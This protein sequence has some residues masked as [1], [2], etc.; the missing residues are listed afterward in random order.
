MNNKKRTGR[1]ALILLLSLL[2][3]MTF[4]PTYAFA[5]GEQGVTVEATESSIILHMGGVGSSG[6]AQIYSYTADSYF[7]A[8]PYKGISTNLDNGVFVS[9][10]EMGTTADIE[11]PR[12]TED[13][14]D[15]LYDKYYVLQGDK[16]IAGPFY[17]SEIASVGGRNVTPFEAATKKGL[18]H[19]DSST[20]NTAIDMG[21]GN[22][23]IN[24]DLGNT[25]Y[26]NEDANGNPID[27]SG[28]DAIAFTSGGE[29]FYFD[30]N[31]VESKDRTIGDYTKNGI[32]VSLVVITW[33][34]RAGE[35]YPASFRYNTNNTDTQ[36]LGFNTSN[37][38]GRKYWVAAMEFLAD[39]YSDKETGFVDQF[40]VGN[41]IDYTYDW[42]LIQPGVVNGLY[43]RADFNT[44]MEEYARTFRLA[45]LAVKKYNSGAKVLLSITHN[46]AESSLTSYGFPSDRQTTAR[47]NSYAPKDMVDWLV[48]QES[49][50]GNFNWGLAVHPYPVGT[51]SSNPVKS[52]L[53]P[54]LAG[55]PNAHPITGNA[56]TTPWI[57]VSNL[58]LYQTYLERPVNQYKGETRTVSLTEASICNEDKSGVSQAEYER[59]T[60]EQA[61]SI[62]MMY[63]RA[64]CVP[65][66]NEIAY[67][68]YHDQTQGGSY[69]LGLTE[70][71]GREKP[72]AKVWKY[73]DTD[74]SFEYSNRYLKYIDPKAGSYKDLMNAAK[75]V[76]NWDSNWTDQNLMPRSI[77]PSQAGRTDAVRIF[78][79]TRYETSLKA[80]DA[81]KAQLG[82]EQF[83]AVILA[84]G[85]NFAD[86]LAGS[87]LASVRNAPILLVRNRDVEI[88]PVQEYIRKNLKAGGTI[89]MLGGEA[90]VPQA[91]VAG[92][93]GY[94]VKRLGGT[95]R[96]DT[97]VK[98]L[99][100]AEIFA[101][102][103]TDYLVASGNGFADSLSASATG[104][105]IILVKNA[106]QP[107][108]KDYIN[109]LK[110]KN[111]YVIGG[112][113][114]VNADMEKAF[115]GLG[116]TVRIGGATRYET[117][118]N[119]ARTFFDSPDCAVTAFGANFPDGLCGGPLAYAMGG[120]LILATSGKADAAVF[121]S[122]AVGI[123]YGTILGGP[124]LIND[125]AARLIFGLRADAVI[126]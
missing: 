91:S 28:R 80:A 54:S 101:G 7:H 73:I 36:T 65:C 61:A 44:F 125:A 38:L 26:A 76:Y 109:S 117:S 31:Y 64:A 78:G 47:Y 51:T 94:T 68:E 112:T 37:P 85:T 123:T 25:I 118:V 19:E 40:I 115:S 98:I 53:T 2:M 110:G 27:N 39:R 66:I 59:S 45:D 103:E 43:Q 56:D 93:S 95:D 99:K 1:K 108:Q 13:G 17:A 23:V 119:V 114:A 60:M 8:D 16:I 41:E 97:N 102:A 6:T 35:N 34:W 62:A 89:Y 72:A 116:K 79:S 9:D 22:T 77:D 33:A 88:K 107:S 106:V 120:P 86:A 58:E 105:P 24:W 71:D 11:C 32:N 126:K 21:A 55:V 96:Y 82:V 30:R 29:T 122:D 5:D 113:G 124:T 69:Q 67:F 63:Y 3:C 90:V 111:F 10:Y 104:K 100:E 57:T 70:L 50:R 18:T 12:Y 92:L 46:W 20:I 52:D 83:D 81:Y 74:K 4:V 42:Y 14:A 15:H 48:K 75:T 121:Y 87:Y 49:A 84:C